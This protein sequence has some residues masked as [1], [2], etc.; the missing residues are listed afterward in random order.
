[1]PFATKFFLTLGAVNAMFSVLIGAFAAHGLKDKLSVQSLT[2][3]QTGVEYHFYHSLGL[4]AV[5]L[6]FSQIPVTGIKVTGST[7]FVRKKSV[8]LPLG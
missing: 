8:P 3:F 6:I 1:M 2:T 7:S 4:L 5:G